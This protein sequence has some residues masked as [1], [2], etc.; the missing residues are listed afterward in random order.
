M[1][2]RVLLVLLIIVALVANL[3]IPNVFTERLQFSISKLTYECLGA[4]LFGLKFSEYS[5]LGLALAFF[6]MPRV[7]RVS[8]VLGLT[9]LFSIAFMTGLRSW[10]LP[11]QAAV[12]LAVGSWGGVALIGALA[13]VLKRVGWTI[14]H[15]SLSPAH[16]KQSHQ[17]N[18]KF[19]FYVMV[20]VG[21][22]TAMLK[23]VLP[24]ETRSTLLV[25]LPSIC[26]WLLWL[27]ISISVI[28][29]VTVFATL[30]QKPG[31]ARTALLLLMTFGPFLFHWVASII[32]SGIPAGRLTFTFESIAIV[33]SVLGGILAGTG[34][35]LLA[36]RRS[37]Y[38]LTKLH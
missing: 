28:L 9:T 37:G 15:R 22:L 30:N 19:L 18:V 1:P 34:L 24:K 8:L 6:P 31:R 27:F 35:A 12:I 36:L 13:A 7:Q 4:F 29:L 16:E 10:Q 21:V 11:L 25:D 38:R 32:L 2:I 3:V 23:S 33:Y 26:L 17:F 14:Q 20:G 5:L